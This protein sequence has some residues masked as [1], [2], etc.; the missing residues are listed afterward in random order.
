MITIHPEILQKTPGFR[1]GYLELEDLTVSETPAEFWDEFDMEL[2]A[3]REMLEDSELA[4]TPF[5]EGMR[6]LYRA[7][8]VD[9]ARY[10]PS[11]ERL[12]RRVLKKNELFKVNTVVDVCNRISIRHMLPLGLYD[13]EK[14]VGKMEFRFGKPG[15]S[16]L[17]ITGLDI[18]AED[19][20]VVCDSEGAIGSATTDS[21]RTAV[22]EMSKAVVLLVYGPDN[23]TDKKLLAVLE[24]FTI[25]ISA[26][27]EAPVTQKACLVIPPEK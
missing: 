16:Y 21:R 18:T 17:G 7:W 27:Q 1:F 9:P 19:K 8:R 3:V 20:P 26:L 24:D 13:R 10:R 11:A 14:V 2:N 6:K 4:K 25:M 15:Q 22:D 23:V 12:L 5:I